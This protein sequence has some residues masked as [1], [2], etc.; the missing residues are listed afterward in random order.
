MSTLCFF[1]KNKG[2]VI[3]CKGHANSVEM[4]IIMVRELNRELFGPSEKKM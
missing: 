3:L 2:H 1:S 4:E